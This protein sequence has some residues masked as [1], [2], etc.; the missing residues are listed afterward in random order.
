MVILTGLCAKVRHR[1]ANPR[2]GLPK[3][4]GGHTGKH[5]EWIYMSQPDQ[6]RA[7]RTGKYNYG[8]VRGGLS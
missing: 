1:E 6:A 7:E 4:G 8:L 5:G 2:Y 3:L